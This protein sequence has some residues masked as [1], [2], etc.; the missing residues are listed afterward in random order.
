MLQ[1]QADLATLTAHSKAAIEVLIAKLATLQAD[2]LRLS[3]P[4]PEV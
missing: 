1:R 3:A 2:T 4:S